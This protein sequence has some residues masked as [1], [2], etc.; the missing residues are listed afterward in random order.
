MKHTQEQLNTFKDIYSESYGISLTSE[1]TEVT[2]IEITQLLEEI[3][4]INYL[5]T[6]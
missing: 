2:I 3:I 5:K 4:R 6:K 1:E